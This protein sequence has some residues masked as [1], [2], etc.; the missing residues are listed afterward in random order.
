VDDEGF[1]PLLSRKI[2]NKM[3]SSCKLQR[4]LEKNRHKKK[5]LGAHA[6]L[7]LPRRNLAM[8]TLCVVLWLGRKY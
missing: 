5:D 2:K 8:T 1:T 3:K 7:V 6:G 4:S